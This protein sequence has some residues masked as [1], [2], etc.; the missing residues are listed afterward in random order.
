MRNITFY[1]FKNRIVESENGS[2]YIISDFMDIASYE[3]VRKTLSRLVIEGYLIRVMR[4]I[5]KKPNFNKYLQSE[6]PVSPDELAKAI[7]RTN[8]W[9]IGP[10]EDAALNILGLSSQV[11]SEYNYISNGPYKKIK[12]EGI[13]IYFHNR[14]NKNITGYSYKTI[15]II[16]ALRTLGKDRI[17]DEIRKLILKKCSKNDLELL[18][19]DGKNTNRWIFEE[20]IKILELGGY[21]YA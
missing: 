21:V 15:L 16:E 14:A 8:N 11:P 2:I 9:T 7:A 6:I 19:Q 5:Y 18:Y 20:I 13:T 3:V 12:Y 10:K 1:K 17:D 4:G